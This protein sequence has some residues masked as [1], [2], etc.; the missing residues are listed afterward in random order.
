METQIKPSP[1]AILQIGTGFWA[2]K[3]LLTA[4]NMNL[5][6]LLAN[7]EKSGQDIQAK[8]GLHNRSL[9]DF[10]D[11]LVALGFLSRTG[12]KET[13]VYKNTEDTNL[14]LDK[15]K[16]S[17]IGGILEMANNRLYPFWNDLEEGLKTGLPQN[18][19]KNNG[20]P[21][22]ELIYADPAKLSE[23][24][25]AM[26]G[27]QTGNFMTFSKE[28]DFSNYK[29]LCDI[30]G[31]GG[32]FSAH[33]VMN[34]P[35]IH[36]TS[37]DLLP[38]EPIAKDIINTM[39]LSDNVTLASGDFFED[40]FPKADIITMGNVLH[41]WGEQDKLMLIE[42]AYRA[43][44]IGGALVVIENIIDDARSKN[45]FGLLMSLNMLIE[46]EKGFDFT[47]EDFN[48]WTK[49]VGFKSTTLLPLAGPASAAIAYK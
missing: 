19:S 3:T 29:T 30:G 24:I 16:P 6:T 27:V 44:P 9:Y 8:L 37:F 35:H 28:F 31:S 38:V 2:S 48:K 25:H 1:A 14:F 4:V 49:Q 33:I 13:A 40:D 15:N 10:L 12:I 36:C 42:K 46:T 5:F 45:A 11:A 22:F 20:Q 47:F 39:N 21:P 23:F 41:D 32:H 26:A 18:E 43:L 34:N 7:G 17:Y